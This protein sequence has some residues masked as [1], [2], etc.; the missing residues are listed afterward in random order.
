LQLVVLVLTTM[1]ILMLVLLVRVFPLQ[2]LV[3]LQ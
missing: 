1:M 2:V 3:L